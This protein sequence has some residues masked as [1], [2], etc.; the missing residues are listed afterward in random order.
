MMERT[1]RDRSTHE[2]IKSIRESVDVMVR[3]LKQQR[4]TTPESGR[5]VS[6][7]TGQPEK[8]S[9]QTE[10]PTH[11]ILDLVEHLSNDIGDVVRD[12]K[13]LRK[14][15]PATYFKNRS[16]IRDTFE[17]MESS[18]G[19]CHDNAFAIMDALQFQ[20]ITSRQIGQTSQLLDEV[21]ARLNSIKEFFDSND[22]ER[23]NRSDGALHTRC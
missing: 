23:E 5:R 19:M 1:Y 20:E 3:H 16:K 14:A 7:A 17:R 11:L 22:P 6:G 10:E 4:E 13:V 21:E 15:L 12:L 2:G 8:I 18:T 9:G